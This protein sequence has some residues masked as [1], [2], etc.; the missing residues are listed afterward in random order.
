MWAILRKGSTQD[1]ILIRSDD[2]NDSN[3]N[4]K[5]SCSYLSTHMVINVW[6]DHQYLWSFSSNMMNEG[7]RIAN[8]IHNTIIRRYHEQVFSIHDQNFL[9]LHGHQLNMSQQMSVQSVIGKY[10]TQGITITHVIGGHIHSAQGSEYS[11]RSSSL[12]GGDPYAYSA[13]G[14]ASMASQ[15]FH[16]ISPGHMDSVKVDLQSVEGVLDIT[17]WMKSRG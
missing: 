14:Y 17:V 12:C 8:V 4:S 15:N 9:L 16:I 5:S 11:S 2:H 6:R 13:L 10:S 3:S 7:N 1:P